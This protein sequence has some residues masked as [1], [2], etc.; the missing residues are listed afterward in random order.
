MSSNPSQVELGVRSSTSTSYFNHKFCAF[1]TATIN[2]FFLP[3]GTHYCMDRQKNH[4]MT[5]FLNTATHDQPRKL[6][7][8]PSSFQVQLMPYPLSHI[9]L[10]FVLLLTPESKAMEEFGVFFKGLL[11]IHAHKICI[12]IHTCKFTGKVHST[13]AQQVLSFCKHLG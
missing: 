1:S 13:Y 3:P 12:Y 2:I 8:R 6:T 11:K 7:S 9:I 5:S 10:C 4:E